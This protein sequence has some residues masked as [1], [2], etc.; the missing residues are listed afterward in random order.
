MDPAFQKYFDQFSEQFIKKLKHHT[1]KDPSSIDPASPSLESNPLAKRRASFDIWKNAF[2]EGLDI[3]A[4]NILLIHVDPK[5]LDL[6]NHELQGAEETLRLFCSH[7]KNM[8]PSEFLNKPYK[9]LFGF[10]EVSLQIF[11]D[12]ATYLFDEK[13]HEAAQKVL[14]VIVTLSPYVVTYW[15]ALGVT[16]HAQKNY[17]KA[18]AVYRF[19]Y[20]LNSN[21][22][23]AYIHILQCAIESNDKQLQRECID[24]LNTLFKNNESENNLWEETFKRLISHV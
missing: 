20:K 15:I 6:F 3:V 2:L 18:I 11:Y 22:A 8:N 1:Q 17:P 10:S 14:T 7:L 19:A 23:I 24:Q 12:V 5:S 13:Q 16:Y 4:E 21:K 9:D